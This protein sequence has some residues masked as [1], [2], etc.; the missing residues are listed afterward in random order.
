MGGNDIWILLF[1]ISK[2]KIPKIKRVNGK[3]FYIFYPL[4][5]LIL[6]LIK[7]VN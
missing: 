2:I 1:N 3:Y 5:V 7:V 6:K 4:H